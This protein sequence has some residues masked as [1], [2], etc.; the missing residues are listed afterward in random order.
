MKVFRLFR[1]KPGIQWSVGANH[2]VRTYGEPIRV[3]GKDTTLRLKRDGDHWLLVIEGESSV[4]VFD[5]GPLDIPKS[6]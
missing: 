6:C 3:H 2:N 4:E 1:G 5:D